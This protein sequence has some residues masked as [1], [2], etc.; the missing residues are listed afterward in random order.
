MSVAE[1]QIDIPSLEA[2]LSADETL[3]M[4]DWD[5]PHRSKS[6]NHFWKRSSRHH[7]IA[8]WSDAL[9]KAQP[10]MDPELRNRIEWERDNLIAPKVGYS[11]LSDPRIFLLRYMR[12][13]YLRYTCLNPYDLRYPTHAIFEW[14]RFSL[15]DRVKDAR[16][17][18]REYWA[19]LL[20]VSAIIIA[21]LNVAGWY[22]DDAYH[23]GFVETVGLWLAIAFLIFVGTD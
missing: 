11:S 23:L 8:C 14:D 10:L 21:L 2:V 9:A 16:Y 4:G 5:D 1:K 13:H 3:L 17:L 7:Y 22:F 18:L 19:K 6:Y 20:I 15:F 12:L